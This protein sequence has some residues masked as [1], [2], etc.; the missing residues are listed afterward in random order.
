MKDMGMSYF[1][2]FWNVNDFSKFFMYCFY[3]GLRVSYPVNQLIIR[4]RFD[5][6]T[7]EIEVENHTD[8]DAVSDEDRALMNTLHTD[9]GY[10]QM[11]SILNGIL[12]LQAFVK[13]LF[14]LRVNEKVG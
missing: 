5:P 3:F 14:Y 10:T 7:G 8:G 12:V 1:L 6:E 13:F 11:I 2:D 9:S 4:R